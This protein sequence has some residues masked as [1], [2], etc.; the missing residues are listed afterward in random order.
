MS[1]AEPDTAVVMAQDPF[2][3]L[4]NELF[5]VV[6][7]CL[8][9]SSI[10]M[11]R[12]TSTQY[13]SKCLCPAFKRYYSHRMIDLTPFS[14]QRLLQLATHPVLGP[15]INDLT[16][17]HV[18]YDPSTWINTI[19]SLR[20]DEGTIP[21]PKELK[22]QF[23]VST[24]HLA[25]LLSKRQQ[26]QGQFIDD[27]VAS[28]AQVLRN[29]GSL[30][31][32]R[33]GTCI[34]RQRTSDHF[35]LYDA[36]APGGFNWNALWD[37]CHRLLKIVTLA[38]TRSKVNVDTLSVFDKCFGKVQSKFLTEISTDLT[39]RGFPEATGDKIKNLH[40][41]FST[42]TVV[43]GSDIAFMTHGSMIP[44]LSERL[45]EG[46]SSARDPENFPGVAAFLK[47]TPELE[48]LDLYMYNTLD[49]PPR[50]YD[51]VFTHIAKEVLL[52]KLRRL[53]LR[54]IRTT[55]EALLLFLRN[56]PG[57]TGLDL[58]D[59]HVSRGDWSPLLKHFQSMDKLSRLHL[60]NCWS[61]PTHLLN[62][63]PENK[64][65]DDGKRGHG[66]SY[67]TKNGTMIHTRDITSEE[68][69]QEGGLRFVKM[70]GSTRGKGS[71]TLM[72][73]MKERREAYGPP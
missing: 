25:W 48:S 36:A 20:R 34:V 6:L 44:L 66:H 47:L 60:E 14:V 63:E 16:I 70:K 27:I 59:V 40:L 54:G 23:S 43:L 46:V 49:G 29:I 8:D 13:A 71:R 9:L 67:S 62:L 51:I 22:R 45:P 17:V 61:E 28:L 33:L 4:P 58:R 73:W 42:A 31:S 30:G 1:H 18:F 65:F 53:T 21:D 5:D 69:R 10:K 24:G 11:L 3:A 35:R 7:T 2:L 72:A 15:A 38:M 56:H 19:N 52:P 68:L 12:L 26:Q 57:I 41:S 55:K 50:A 39:S 37:D 64:L 32:L